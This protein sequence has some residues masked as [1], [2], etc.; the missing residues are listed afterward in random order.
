MENPRN[1]KIEGVTLNWAR[2]DK[3]VNPFG[4]EQYELQIATADEAKVKHLEENFVSFRKNKDG[5]YKKDDAGMFTASLKRKA[6]KADGSSNGKVR[7]VKADLSEMSEDDVRAL[8]NGSEGN[9]I[10]FQYP[11]AQMG[12]SGVASS[13]TAIQVTKYERFVPTG[14]GMDFEAVGEVAQ[15]NGDEAVSMF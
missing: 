12:R 5:S 10:L 15:D 2:L 14:T 11:W 8:G 1:F 9:I 6:M 4:T 7:V 13:L 3:P